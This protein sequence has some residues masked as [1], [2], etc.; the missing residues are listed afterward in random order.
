V[1]NGRQYHGAAGLLVIPA[2]VAWRLDSCR[3]FT[4]C[5]LGKVTRA[6]VGLTWT[7]MHDRGQRRARDARER[8]TMHSKSQAASIQSA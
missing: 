3:M 7:D 4:A 8:M 5:T 2:R 1:S 6:G